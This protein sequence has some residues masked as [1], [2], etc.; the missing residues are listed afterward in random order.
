MRVPARRHVGR[1]LGLVALWLALW[2][3]VTT[4]NVLSGLVVAVA[5]QLLPDPYHP[6]GRLSFR[7]LAALRFGGWFLWK[8]VEASVVVAREVVT[9][10]DRINTG[11]VEVP[12]I[13]ASD[14]LVTLVANTV[15]LTPGSITVEVER[16]PPTL[17]VHALHVHT[18]EEVRADIHRL[19]VL[20][21]RAFGSAAA[22]EGLRHDDS[23]TEDVVL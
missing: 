16:D 19:E 11:V 6:G 1:T 22:L 10:Q 23:R 2:G 18:V 13:G 15:G 4:A 8:L 21:I 14:A 20:A 5:V 17:F 3:T 12:L 7:P 9:P